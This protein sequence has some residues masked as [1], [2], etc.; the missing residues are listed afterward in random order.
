MENFQKVNEVLE[1]QKKMHKEIMNEYQSNVD[2]VNLRITNR[3]EQLTLKP[4]VEAFRLNTDER[5]KRRRKE[6]NQLLIS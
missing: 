2:E 5:A 1:K 4:K 3:L 6:R